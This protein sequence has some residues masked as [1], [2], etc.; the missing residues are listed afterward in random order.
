MR[1]LRPASLTWRRAT[2][3]LVLAAF[4]PAPAAAAREVCTGSGSV[5]AYYRELWFGRPGRR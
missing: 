3:L 5:D 1:L 4:G 2:L